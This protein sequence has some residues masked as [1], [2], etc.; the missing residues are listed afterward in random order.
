MYSTTV[1]RICS[2]TAKL[3][4][5]II[6][7]KIPFTIMDQSIMAK[8]YFSQTNPG[9]VSPMRMVEKWLEDVKM[10]DLMLY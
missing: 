5:E 6:L 3:T 1:H 10:E 7:G 8:K 2:H 4:A 9:S